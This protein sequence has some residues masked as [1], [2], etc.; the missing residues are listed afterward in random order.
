ML[1]PALFQCI[2]IALYAVLLLP[3]ILDNK[4]LIPMLQR[5]CCYGGR[6]DHNIYVKIISNF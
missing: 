2:A 4:V 1:A 6:N 3:F 5:L